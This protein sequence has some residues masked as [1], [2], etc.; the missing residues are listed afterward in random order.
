MA[1]PRPRFDLHVPIGREEVL[2]RVKDSLLISEMI[3]GHVFPP[4]RIELTISERQ[5]HLWSPLL[6]VKI[7]EEAQ[8]SHLHAKFGPHPHI[9]TLYVALY[10]LSVMFAIGCAVFGISQWLVGSTPYA[11]YLTPI[12]I[13]SAAL[14]YGASFVGQGLGSEQMYEV[15][16][17]LDNAVSQN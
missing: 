14:V 4:D 2:K 7:Q 6:T 9:W 3:Q 10:A 1:R 17:F 16:A 12:A 5:R 15:R 11:L 8:Q 13:I